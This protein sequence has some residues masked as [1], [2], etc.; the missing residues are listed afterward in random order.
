MFEGSLPFLARHGIFRI[1]LLV[2]G[3][4]DWPA[5]VHD[6]GELQPSL[7]HHA[8]R[9]D[10]DRHGRRKDARDAELGEAHGDE[11]A[12]TFGRIA[13]AP[14]GTTQPVPELDIVWRVPRRG[15]EVEPADERAARLL[16]RCPEAEPRETFVI[17]EPRRQ[18]VRFDLLA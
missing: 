1:T 11:G 5:G 2:A 17:A 4:V 8:A 9:G 13:L 16:V 10:V 15:A 12:R 6:S 18:D 7:F 14:C 3:D